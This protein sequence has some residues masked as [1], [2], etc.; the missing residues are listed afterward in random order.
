MEDDDNG[1]MI[2]TSSGAMLF[3][4]QPREVSFE[5][6]ASYG[7]NTTGNELI[8][9]GV[10]VSGP[11]ATLKI[12]S[13][14]IAGNLELRDNFLDGQLTQLDEMARGLVEMFAEE[15]QTSGGKAALAGLFTWSGG[16]TVPTSATLEKGIAWTLQ[17]NPLVDSQQGGDPTLL[18]DGAINGD[19][20]Y[21]YNTTG[22]SGYS[23]RL[24]QLSDAFD[25]RP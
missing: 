4:T 15:D 2:T 6:I 17:V 19:A 3:D 12:N 8:V 20:D 7:P 16:P 5:P 21:T 10:T 22:A 14:K 18:R 13:G 25:E 11:N 9:D 24:L 1:I 23:D